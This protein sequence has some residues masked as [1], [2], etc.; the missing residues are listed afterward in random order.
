[1]ERQKLERER[2]ERERLERE[3]V[4]IEQ[5]PCPSQDM[6]VSHSHVRAEDT[7][8]PSL[9]SSCLLVFFLSCG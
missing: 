3:R 8:L 7:P 1:M 9:G 6:S 4:R 5:V 2:L